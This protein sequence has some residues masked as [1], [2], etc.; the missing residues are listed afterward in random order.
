MKSDRQHTHNPSHT[1]HP[2]PSLKHTDTASTDQHTASE[3]KRI[4]SRLSCLVTIARAHG[5]AADA[6]QLMHQFGEATDAFSADA[7]LHAAHDLGLVAERRK[8]RRE[9]LC[10]A[11]MPAIFIDNTGEFG[12]IGRIDGGDTQTRLL[13]HRPTSTKPVWLSVD[14]FTVNW[15]SELILFTSR[16]SVASEIAR[17]DLSWF[18]PAMVK[19]RRLLLEVLVVS[20]VLQL[21]ALVTPLFF[22]VVMDKVLV[23]RGFSTLNVI[24]IG[25]LAVSVFEVILGGLRSYVH[26]HTCSRIDVEFGARLFRH[27]LALPLNWFQATRGGDTVARVREL[28]KIRQFLTGDSITLVL[29]LVFSLI[30]IGVMLIYSPALTLIVVLSLPCYLLLS[31]V[32][33]P[34]LRR[35]LDEQ[36]KHGAENQA[37]LVESVTAISTVK[38]MA[39]EPRW[40][41]KWEQQLAAYVK[42]AFR[43]A[44]VANWAGNGV[45]LVSKLVT[46]CTMWLGA[47]LVIDGELSVGQLIAFNMLAGHVAAPV[48]RLAQMWSD[49]QQVGVSVERLGDILNTETET[50]PAGITLPTIKGQIVFDHVY[51]RYRPDRQEVLSNIQLVIR[52]GERIGIVGR[53]G[54]GKSTLSLLLQRLHT[55]QRGRILIDGLDIAIADPA[56]LRRQMGVVPQESQLFRGTLRQ[57]IA[58]TDPGAPLEKVMQMANLAGAHGFITELP[59]GYETVIGEHGT[60]LSGGQKQ[61]IAIARALM[62]DPRILIFDE[63]TSALDYESERMIQNH[64]EAICA[65]R[66]V[67]IIAHRLSAVRDTDRILV[68]DQGHLVEQGQH[69]ELL[70]KD[71]GWYAHL[72]RMQVA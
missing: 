14:E 9:R 17:F 45:S 34:I 12:I 46:V 33:T 51:F 26:S 55:A 61:R 15:T 4:L 63:A 5:I 66:T 62:R 59:E 57:N 2:D 52:P 1:T 3:T 64:M 30:F 38:T 49:F 11:A 25:L 27:L 16:A 54:S 65:N 23:H 48:I 13:I 7:I 71:D 39:V 29:D 8:I 72:H 44:L 18:I 56:S 35:R 22:Q 20:L 68:M 69:R 43:A 40:C 36:F 21:F 67:I 31:I 24:A 50:K 58:L 60:G 6:G 37:F 28:E 10:K 53:S 70:A 47:R 42:A 32:A 19:Y 41:H